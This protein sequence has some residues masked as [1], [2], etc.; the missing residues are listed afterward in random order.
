MLLDDVVVHRP[1][2]I[3]AAAGLRKELGS[4]SIILGGGTMVVPDLRRG[5]K[6]ARALISLKSAQ[7]NK[8]QRLG[9]ALTLGAM[10]SYSDMLASEIIREGVP[11]LAHVAGQITGGPQIR[12]QG[13]I[14]GSVSFANPSSDIP[15][16]MLALGATFVARC[17]DQSR[18]IAAE[19]FFKSAFQTALDAREVLSSIS[20]PT[21]QGVG[22]YY[23]LK[24][25]E[26][27]WPIVTAAC[28]A[29]SDTAKKHSIRVAVGGASSRPYVRTCSVTSTQSEELKAVASDI[30]AAMPDEWSDEIAGAGYRR[31][32]APAVILRS[33]SA[34]LRLANA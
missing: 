9:D 28:V 11:L 30:A 22:G 27:S 19:E 7:L 14:G 18:D 2:S 26:S 15:A 13:T 12:N 10:V 29:V 5:T 23:K 6:S 31:R 33:I 32:V 25:S 20:I 21:Q 17:G 34:A 1:N 8:I 16:L 3:G 4:S 24:F